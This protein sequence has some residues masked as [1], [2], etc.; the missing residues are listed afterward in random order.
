MQKNLELEQETPSPYRDRG[1]V[2]RAAITGLLTLALLG[3]VRWASDITNANAKQVT[4]N[5]TRIQ[6]TMDAPTAQAAPE[7]RQTSK[8]RKRPAEKP[9]RL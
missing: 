9:K 5:L 4:R 8:K 2:G 3:A 6:S 7:P 1:V